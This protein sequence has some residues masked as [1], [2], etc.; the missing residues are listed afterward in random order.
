MQ[1]KTNNSGCNG[2][3]QGTNCVIWTGQPIPALGIDKGDSMTDITCVIA[4]QI[5]ALA[6]PLDLSTVSIQ[7]LIDNLSATEPVSRTVATMLQ[8][9]YDSTCTLNETVEGVVAQIANITTV[10]TPVLN[11][12]C[13]ATF[14]T[15]GNVLPYTTQSVLQS[16]ITT[17]CGQSVTIAGLSGNIQTLTASVAALQ[18]VPQYTEPVLSSCLY[19]AT[20]TSSALQITAAALCSYQAEV[21]L[22]TDIQ[23]ALARMPSSFTSTYGLTNGWIVNPTNLAQS[24]SNALIV[25]ANLATAVTSIQNTCC[26]VSCADVIVDFDVSLSPNRL[27][28]TLFFAVKSSVPAGFTE[29]NSQGDLLTVTDGNGA[30]YQTYINVIQQLSNPSGKV[31]D[32]SGTA[33]DPTTTYT[34]NLTSS[35]TDGSITCVKCVT[36]EATF[37]DTCSFCTISVTAATPSQSNNVVLVYNLPGGPTQY[38]TVYANQTQAIQANANVTSLIVNGSA[39]YTSTCTL[40]QP[41]QTSCYQMSW[42]ISNSS[43]GHDA[44]FTDASLQ[45]ISVLGVQYPI[46]CA[47]GSVSQGVCYAAAFTNFYPATLGLLGNL[48]FQ[49]LPTFQNFI[50][51]QLT[52]TT[53]SSIAASMQGFIGATGAPAD[54]DTGFGTDDA[55]AGGAYITPI[56]SNNPNCLGSSSQQQSS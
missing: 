48:K 51:F 53:T 5:V 19:S 12:G 27:T 35:L 18:A 41:S 7:C 47:V 14:D 4:Q 25:I 24:Y 16:L 32:L 29:V 54:G 38:L 3:K 33:L 45:W 21:G 23:S 6:A 1:Q 42:G 34:F 13:L 11:L 43:G 26:Q 40:P 9:A 49:F 37:S 52:F 17:L 20:K 8:I 55:F 46:S 31:I 15:Y 30:Q 10:T 50:A 36:K 28:A 2:A 22:V 44:I 39:N 56:P